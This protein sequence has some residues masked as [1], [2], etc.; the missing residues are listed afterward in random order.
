MSMIIAN[1]PNG[2]AVSISDKLANVGVKNAAVATPTPE[3][4]EFYQHWSMIDALWG[5]TTALHNPAIARRFLPQFPKEQEQDYVNRLTCSVLTNFYRMTVK[6]A[7]GKIFKK[8]MLLNADVPDAIAELADNIDGAGNDLNTFTRDV[9]EAAINYGHT[10]ILV[11]WAQLPSEVQAALNDPLAGGLAIEKTLGVRP[12]WTH[13]KPT[14]IIGWKSQTVDGQFVLTQ[15]RIHECVKSDDPNN[16]FGQ[17]E[18]QRVRVFDIPGRIR[19]Y[20]LQE[21][22]KGEQ[23]WAEVAD[24]PATMNGKRWTQIPLVPVTVNGVDNMCAMPLLMDM[25]HLNIAHYQSDSDQRNLL[26]VTR[27]PIIF[28]TGLTTDED[29]QFELSVGPFVMNK[30]PTGATLAFVE[31]TGASVKAGKDDIDDLEARI[32]ELALSLVMR[33]Q[34]GRN[35]TATGIAIDSAEADSPL[36]LV[37]LAVQMAVD[38][39]LDWTG[40]WLQLGEDA[41]GTCKINNEFGIAIGDST[42]ITNL[43]AARAAG[44]ISRATYWRELQRRAFLS[45]DFDPDE[46]AAELQIEQS[47]AEWDALSN[48]NAA[49]DETA[50]A[51]GHIHILQSGGVTNNVN[52]HFHQW[53]PDG[54]LTT[55]AEGHSHGLT[56]GANRPHSQPQ[57]QQVP[58]GNQSLPQPA[59]PGPNPGAQKVAPGTKPPQAPAK[60]GAAATK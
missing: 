56:R 49:G 42:Q 33:E 23:E 27:V 52:G 60:P 47:G 55:E 8:P 1:A 18:K 19:V 41:G 29:E 58:G 32:G 35:P 26:H 5:G 11:D 16:E 48:L 40:Q 15:L 13:I 2:M 37:A 12:Y 34:P 36:Q 57:P 17:I 50:L 51:D 54:L 53:T 6:R 28:G 45:D 31:H 10:F 25:A 46:E 3:Y 43:I 38:K 14:Q 39:A 22:D 20:E 24:A 59:G 30:A 21:N 4:M 44:E 7:T 9:S